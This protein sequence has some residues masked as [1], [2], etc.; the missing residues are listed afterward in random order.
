MRPTEMLFHGTKADPLPPA[1]DDSV[2]KSVFD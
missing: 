2:E 1:Q